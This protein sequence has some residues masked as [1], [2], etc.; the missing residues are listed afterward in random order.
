MEGIQR[1]LRRRLTDG[2]GRQSADHLAGVDLR[3]QVS[4][5]NV[6][7]QL[8]K[9]HLCQSVNDDGLLGCQIVAQKCVEQLVVRELGDECADGLYDMGGGQ[10]RL[11]RISVRVRGQDTTEIDGRQYLI[12]LA[13]TEHIAY[14]HIPVSQDLLHQ[15]RRLCN[16]CLHERI[17]ICWAER[18]LMVHILHRHGTQLALLGLHRDGINPILTV[19]KLNDGSRH[20]TNSAVMLDVL[21]FH[22]LHQT[23]LNIAR[24]GCLNSR[25]NQTLTSRLRV[26]EELGGQQ[27]VHE[28][29]LNEA[30]RLHTVIVARKVRQCA[31]LQ[32]VL[33]SLALNQLLT[34]QGNHLRDVLRTSL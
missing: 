18:I 3:L 27:A 30:T 25:I 15:I 6:G 16:R 10:I 14:E 12:V 19:G 2:L 23:T 1:K 22:R 26:E 5:A 21:V 20:V 28:G 24:V 7:H 32:G 9:H 31:V 13:E 11:G 4:K 33:N 17:H 34:Q 8:I 29:I